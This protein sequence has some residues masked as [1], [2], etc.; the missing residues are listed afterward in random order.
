MLPEV[1][2]DTHSPAVQEPFVEQ[3]DDLLEGPQG[4]G[5]IRERYCLHLVE[6]EVPRPDEDQQ[7]LRPREEHVHPA[8]VVEEP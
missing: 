3:G 5:L 2:R 1:S 8:R 6:E 4:L 7:A